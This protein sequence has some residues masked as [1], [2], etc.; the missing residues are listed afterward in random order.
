MLNNPSGQPVQGIIFDAVGT[1]IEPEPPVLIAYLN[2][3]RRQNI[4]LDPHTVRDRYRAAFHRQENQDFRGPLA[5]DEATERRRWRRIVA[6]ALPEIPDLNLAFDE[7]WIHFGKPESWRLY[8]DVPDALNRLA[9]AGIPFCIASNFD[10]RLRSVVEGLPA[11][12]RFAPSLNISTEVGR[13]KPH[14]ALYEAARSSL[15][16]DSAE[17]VLCV[18][19]DPENDLM[20]PLRAGYQ[21]LLIDRRGHHPEF[22]PS[23]NSLT[24]LADHLTTPGC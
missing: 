11:L 5:T 4:Q 12:A 10:A 19:D 1:L 16:I 2:A 17:A 7:L 21:A 20:G 18:G 8:D 22:S 9:N 13:R 23:T 14:R 24:A 15:G 3:A 6:E